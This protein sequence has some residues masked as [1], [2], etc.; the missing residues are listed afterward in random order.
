MDREQLE[1]AARG[2]LAQ[3]EFLIGSYPSDGW[4]GA[5]QARSSHDKSV[6][7]VERA[8]DA[9]LPNWHELIPD[10]PRRVSEPATSRS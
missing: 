7:A 6:R 10:L 9:S 1:P 8:L 3:W 2:F 5:A 4:D